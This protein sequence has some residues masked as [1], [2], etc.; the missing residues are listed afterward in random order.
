MS[1]TVRHG[2][3]VV[4][5]DLYQ[6]RPVGPVS[7]QSSSRHRPTV[8]RGRL[9]REVEHQR[10]H[11]P[12]RGSTR[13]QVLPWPP[14]RTYQRHRFVVERQSV[15]Q[16]RTGRSREAN[17]ELAR[18]GFRGG[19]ERRPWMSSAAC[20]PRTRNGMAV[21]TLRRAPVATAGKRLRSSVARTADW[22]ISRS[23]MSWGHRFVVIVGPLAPEGGHV[24]LQPQHGSCRQGG[25]DR[26]A[27]A[28]S[29]STVETRRSDHQTGRG[30]AA[31]WARARAR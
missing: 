21:I 23:S 6:A 30:A 3:A 16:T 13:C 25:G 15:A 14:C 10:G 4:L 31:G 26:P 1:P 5:A 29:T 9:G 7:P 12:G 17:V 18:R 19:V 22:G 27:R 28:P 11:D 24:R 8:A 2:L 20:W